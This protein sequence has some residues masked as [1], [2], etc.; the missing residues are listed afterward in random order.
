MLRED[1]SGKLYYQC[2]G[3]FE[4]ERPSCGSKLVMGKGR[5]KQLKAQLLAQKEGQQLA[6]DNTKKEEK[7]I[8]N[9]PVRDDWIAENFA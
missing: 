3:D 1:R 6:N 5:S 4:D 7:T 8:E 9:Q 2:N